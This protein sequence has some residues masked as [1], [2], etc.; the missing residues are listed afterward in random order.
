MIVLESVVY[1]LLF[2]SSSE[3]GN[4]LLFSRVSCDVCAGRGSRIRAGWMLLIWDREVKR[5]DDDDG[6]LKG[7]D[8]HMTLGVA[9]GHGRI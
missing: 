4:S 5:R 1:K 9:S 7:I 8:S 6:M 2:F 3:L